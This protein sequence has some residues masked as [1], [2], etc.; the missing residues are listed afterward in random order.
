MSAVAQETPFVSRA[1]RA[2]RGSDSLRVTIP[3]VIAA[4]LGLCAGDEVRWYLD[5]HSGA[6]RVDARP[7]RP[8]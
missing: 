6:I 8:L 3:Q 5:P 1:V 7:K 2:S 4:S